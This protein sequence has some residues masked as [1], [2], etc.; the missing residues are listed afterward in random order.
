MKKKIKNLIVAIRSGQL[1]VIRRAL[2]IQYVKE[3]SE[4]ANIDLKDFSTNP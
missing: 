3:L 2:M 1:S 4:K